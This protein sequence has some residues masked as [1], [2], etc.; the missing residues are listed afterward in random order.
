MYATSAASPWLQVAYDCVPDDA[1]IVL[2]RPDEAEVVLRMGEPQS[3]T[4]SLFQVGADDLLVVTHSQLGVGQLMPAQV[5]A[6][7]AGQFINWLEVGGPDL[8]VQVWTYAADV[9]IQTSFV[10][11]VLHERPVSSM[12]RLAVS[13]QD[14]SDSISSTPGSIGL[15]PRR[16]MIGNTSEILKVASLPV[17]AL[18]HEPTQGAAAQLIACMQARQ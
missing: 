13:A 8:P 11:S 9:D 4:G 14:M 17:L 2:G 10:R 5:E 7:F 1:A 18:T 6:L 3:L 15:L 16:W 12:A